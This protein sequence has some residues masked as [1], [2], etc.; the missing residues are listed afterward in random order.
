MSRIGFVSVSRVMVVLA[1]L[2]AF[3]VATPGGGGGTLG[4]CS[5][6]TSVTCPT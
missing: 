5:L 3:V 4:T 1:L 2:F 6:Q